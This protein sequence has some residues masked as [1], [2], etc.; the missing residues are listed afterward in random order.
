MFLT[1]KKQIIPVVL[2]DLHR[3][4][5]TVLS[6]Q[7]AET[8]CQN[9]FCVPKMSKGVDFSHVY[10]IENSPPS[11]VAIGK[12][13]FYCVLMIYVCYVKCDHFVLMLY[14]KICV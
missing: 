4:S 5:L 3:Q 14:C 10:M 1:K 8:V 13:C 11:C 12:F 9:K 2:F 7:F 6:K